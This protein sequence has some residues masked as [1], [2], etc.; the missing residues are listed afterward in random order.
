MQSENNSQ[1]EPKRVPLNDFIYRQ[2]PI[3]ILIL[4]T[5]GGLYLSIPMFKSGYL[6]NFDHPMQQGLIKCF[7]D[8]PTVLMP[9]VWCSHMQA[10]LA[11]FQS[12]PIIFYQ[13][14]ILLVPLFGLELA[15]K[16][17]LLMVW[18]LLPTVIAYILWSKG[19]PL[20]GALA[21]TF[22]LLN[23]G[24]QD[25]VGPEFFLIAGSGFNQTL[26]FGLLPLTIW[27]LIKFYQ[28]PTP[29]SLAVISVLT[30]LYFLAHPTTFLLF[31]PILLT[32]TYLYRTS[33][34]DKW[35][36]A[37][38][39]P[40]IVFLL[41]SY[42]LIPVLFNLTSNEFL[43]LNVGITSPWRQAYK[44]LIIDAW[45]P[46]FLIGLFGLIIT[47]IQRKSNIWGFPALAG[48]IL[49]AWTLYPLIAA[50]HLL[51]FAQFARTISLMHSLILIGAA[52]GI[53]SIVRYISQIGDKTRTLAVLIPITIFAV[54]ITSS[55][56][57]FHDRTENIVTSSDP[58][59]TRL[60]DTMRSFNNTKGRILFQETYSEFG[61]YPY[62]TTSIW[63][64]G[65]IYLQSDTIHPTLRFF[66][67]PYAGTKGGMIQ[68]WRTDESTRNEL[69]AILAMWNIEYMVVFQGGALFRSFRFLPGHTLPSS[70]VVF[71][72]NAT[73][74][75]YFHTKNGEIS[76]TIY[77]RTQ[78]MAKVNMTRDSDV[79][80]KVRYW[81][82]WKAYVDSIEVP[83]QKN[84][85]D[86][87]RI[88]VPKGTHKIDFR[89]GPRWWDYLGLMA[90]LAGIALVV[91]L[92]ID[93]RAQ[94]T[95]DNR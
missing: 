2:L 17:I 33:L 1:N 86:F 29:Q 90:T 85:I 37:I 83:V 87:M 11:P 92:W 93:P 22:L 71:Y 79:L 81:A 69:N 95:G 23:H 12:Y 54:L 72:N 47:G 14:V 55:F 70:M 75:S 30:A 94:N 26:A 45:L 66:K 63:G 88:E 34:V 31:I 77:D 10:G 48:G 51:D 43:T 50:S 13:L 82:N 60:I 15:Y 67:F 21:F 8:N 40:V 42:F 20:A 58:D 19:R 91:M 16:I 65:P 78:A 76:Q 57:T 9:S 73:P 59:L 49:C 52:L 24:S 89:Y 64:L 61:F 62:N 84:E 38:V 35:R 53:E 7:L 56:S 25:I 36:L 3:L 74:I 46:T 32:L 27:F 41:S 6:L 18:F 5:L 44:T 80:L 39:Y 28:E 4:A 68:K